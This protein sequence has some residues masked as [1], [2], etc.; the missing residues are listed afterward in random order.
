MGKS[1]R[2]KVTLCRIRLP[3]M[4][5]S[6]DLMRL[7]F[8]NS[9]KWANSCSFPSI[10]SFLLKIWM[11]S[12]SMEMI[13]YLTSTTRPT[14]GLRFLITRE[15][16]LETEKRRNTH[17]FP[18]WNWKWGKWIT[19]GQCSD[20]VPS[21]LRGGRLMITDIISRG[22]L[23]TILAQGDTTSLTSILSMQKVMKT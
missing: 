5:F 13:S 4:T 19:M 21:L 18:S 9:N 11:I 15:S 7:E 12:L 22:G 1:S 17:L 2:T 10:I 23:E 3:L 6:L 14:T 8:T 16:G 20:S